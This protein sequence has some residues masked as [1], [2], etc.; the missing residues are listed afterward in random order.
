MNALFVSLVVAQLAGR[1][2]APSEGRPLFA[3]Q[4]VDR[5]V[6]LLL[7]SR[8]DTIAL[9]TATGVRTSPGKAMHPAGACGVDGRWRVVAPVQLGAETWSLVE[10]NETNTRRV[11]LTARPVSPP[12]P[13]DA[14]GVAV[15]LADG[16]VVRWPLDGA[17]TRVQVGPP[18]AD[19]LEAGALFVSDVAGHLVRG[20]LDGQLWRDDGASWRLDAPFVGGQMRWG[21]GVLAVTRRGA[22]MKVDSSGPSLLRRFSAGIRGGATVWRQ[23][24][25]LID[26][27]GQVWA[28]SDAS[29]EPQL[30][31][32][33]GSPPVAAPLVFDVLDEGAPQLVVPL[34][35]ATAAVLTIDGRVSRAP[36]GLRA[37][38]GLFA[39]ALEAD[40]RPALLAASGAKLAGWSFEPTSRP[41]F[42]DGAAAGLTFE[43]NQAH[44]ARLAWADEPP[45][46]TPVVPELP[47]AADGWSCTS[48]PEP[49]WALVLAL[50]AVW[51]RHN[52]S[53]TRSR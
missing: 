31:A 45:V 14:C 1:P 34:D 2:I 28:L 38:N 52:R 7:V 9:E 48:T 5:G 36:L 10:F 25:V 32:E 13:D 17:A 26:D 3:G 50:L 49:M 19:A 6:P 22:L 53:I 8:G 47:P 37:T 30:L 16:A 20:D 46:P 12:V 18:L 41:L 23:R 40:A 51:Q 33:L 39:S 21:Q 29:A 42:V 11:P 15:A 44:V 27:L 43:R 35:D 4:L 24:L